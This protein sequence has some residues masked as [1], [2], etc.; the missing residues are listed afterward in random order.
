MFNFLKKMFRWLLKQ[1][2]EFNEWIRPYFVYYRDEHK[3]KTNFILTDNST[4]QSS[5][6]SHSNQI[7]TRLPSTKSSVMDIASSTETKAKQENTHVFIGAGPANLDRAL[8]IRKQDPNAKLIFLDKRVSPSGELDRAQARANIFRFPLSE[9]D[10]I[11]QNAFNKEEFAKAFN[12]LSTERNFSEDSGFQYGDTKVF[13]NERFTQIQIRDLQ[14]LYLN[15]L[16]KSGNVTFVD[17]DVDINSFYQVNTHSNL[18]DT[19]LSPLNQEIC[20]LEHQIQISRDDNSEKGQFDKASKLSRLDYLQKSV[21]LLMS[22]K[23][24][25]NITYHNAAGALKEGPQGK[26]TTPDTLIYR[27]MS[28]QPKNTSIPSID[29]SSMP[30]TAMHGTATFSFKNSRIQPKDLSDKTVSLDKTNWQSELAKHGWNLARP[31]RVRLFYANDTLYVGTEIPASYAK[32]VDKN[33]RP[34][35]LYKQMQ[36]DYTRTIAKLM[37]PQFSNDIERLPANKSGVNA[38]SFFLTNRGET[39]LAMNQTDKGSAIFNHGDRRYLPHYQTGS[40]FLTATLQNDAYAN[41]YSKHNF[42][43]LF[44]W[45]KTEGLIN[46]DYQS[47]AK[48]YAKAIGVNVNQPNFINHLSS[49][50]KQDMLNLFQG[51]LYTNVTRDILSANKE[52]VDKYFTQVQKQALTMLCHNKQF[53][54]LIDFF[55]STNST[56]A[57]KNMPAIQHDIAHGPYNDNIKVMM[58]MEMVKQGSDAFLLQV[59]PRMVNVDLS[60]MNLQNPKDMNRLHQLRDSITRDYMKYIDT[61]ELMKDLAPHVK[62]ELFVAL[63]AN[64]NNPA[65]AQVCVANLLGVSPSD[66]QMFSQ[67]RNQILEQHPKSTSS[68]AVR[69]QESTSK[70]LQRM[71]TPPKPQPNCHSRN[72]DSKE[73][74]SIQSHSN[75]S[76]EG[77]KTYQTPTP[78]RTVPNPYSK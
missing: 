73:N 41:I 10:K 14:Q 54:D 3:N 55:K 42:N 28:E 20:D 74:Q 9:R 66:K 31:P 59:I 4:I 13:G 68:D 40:G 43:A 6:K 44:Q 76:P 38:P 29:L 1:Y 12:S 36:I 77:A 46:K 27:P 5:K 25:A 65:K 52:K 69:R 50:Q 22:V 37:L 47:V 2:S 32:Q 61:N 33:G 71:P 16:K 60:E 7:S 63:A 75:L 8:K 30:V 78:C 23:N 56:P 39:G 11:I 18:R 45:A 21:Q 15:D 17:A 19:V 49:K 70:M 51:D 35:E 34:N 62:K 64:P 58:I 72:K 57:L 53:N 26:G 48:E 67:L 24:G